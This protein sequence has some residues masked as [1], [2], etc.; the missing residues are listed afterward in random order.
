MAAGA[1]AGAG[2]I[3]PEIKKQIIAFID[4]E[5]E[6]IKK[7]HKDK[8]SDDTIDMRPM[9]RD[10]DL[11][12]RLVGVDKDFLEATW[13]AM[14]R[15]EEKLKLF[16][17]LKYR[18]LCEDGAAEGIVEPGPRL[19]LSHVATELERITRMPRSAS[20]TTFAKL[21]AGVGKVSEKAEPDSY[22]N[23]LKEGWY[24]AIAK[25]PFYTVSLPYVSKRW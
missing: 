12:K 8:K 24:I 20:S 7:N 22:E 4:K 10:I 11:S 2:G 3:D 18:L 9:F 15:S 16:E 14:D 5:M 21:L 1:G 23:L 17:S 13:G 6:R 25:G 19:T